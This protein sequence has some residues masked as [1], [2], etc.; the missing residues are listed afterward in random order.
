MSEE[1]IGYCEEKV[2]PLYRHPEYSGDRLCG[3]CL[4]SY[5]EDDFERY[6]GELK[7][8]VE[9]TGLKCALLDHLKKGDFV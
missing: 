1:C 6:V 2:G 9:E 4:L 3:D 7:D 8:S 5:W